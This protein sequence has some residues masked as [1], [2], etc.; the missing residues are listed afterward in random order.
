MKIITVCGSLRFYKEMMEITEKMELQGNCILVPIY[1][2]ARP[3]KDDF[4]EE[5]AL[6]LDKMHKE[7][8]KLADAILVVNVDGYIGNSTKSE[9]EFAKSL[10]K[11]ILYYTDLIK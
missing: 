4:I 6:M 11:E 2:H 5:D 9:I 3:N 10:N 1:N 7:R 8:I